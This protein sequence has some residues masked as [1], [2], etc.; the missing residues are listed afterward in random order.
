M[1]IDYSFG[2]L[3]SWFLDFLLASW[4]LDLLLAS[5]FLMLKKYMV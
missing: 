4:F 2:V 1:Y 3:V 5:C